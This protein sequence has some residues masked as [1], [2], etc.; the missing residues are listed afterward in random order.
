M[1]FFIACCVFVFCKEVFGIEALAFE[2]KL[3]GEIGLVFLMWGV[4]PTPRKK[5]YRR[6]LKE[7]EKEKE[8]RWLLFTDTR[9]KKTPP[10]GAAFLV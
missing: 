8:P 9:G 1:A 4:R 10:F 5:E 2:W 3:Q 6:G 7:K